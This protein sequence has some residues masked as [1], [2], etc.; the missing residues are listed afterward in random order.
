[1]TTIHPDPDTASA[2]PRR[3]LH[4]AGRVPPIVWVILLA[5]VVRLVGLVVL[6]PTLDFSLPGNAIHGSEGYDEYA[7]NL[8]ATGVY[9]RTP[10]VA[11]AGLPPFYSYVLAAVY[12]VAGRSFVTVALFHIL[13][14]SVSILLLYRIG[15]GIFPA[16]R[17][18]GRPT[19]EWVG[20]L[21][22]LFTALYPYLV[23]QNLTLVDTP[24]WM[25]LL[26]GFVWAMMRLRQA[27]QTRSAVAFALLSGLL[28]GIATL[29]RPITPPL[30]LLLA[31]WFWLRLSLWQ[32]MWRLALVA[33]VSIVLVLPWIARNYQ[34]FDEFVLMSTT[35]GFN[36]WQGNH[37]GTVPILLSG[38]DVQ[39]FGPDEALI[40]AD[41]T[42]LE[43]DRIGYQLA[44][45]FWR[46]QPQNIAGL[47]LTKFRVYW[48]I[49]I[50]PQRNPQYGE[51]LSVADDGTITVERG[52]TS[53]QGVT[54]A[55][56]QYDSGLFDTL[57]RPVHILYFGGLFL[58]ACVGSLLA[59]PYWRDVSLVW[60][61]Q[62]S[63]T[64]IYVL[65]HPSTRYR[66]PTDPLLFLLSAYTLVRLLG[67]WYERRGAD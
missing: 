1:M 67:W 65:F 4:R 22:A 54:E 37:D 35:S 11:D 30:A 58:L 41:A 16:V 24:L 14:D 36:L 47:M 63:M 66:A 10:G 13:L 53:Q 33:V 7:V 27:T 5:I 60:M 42:D 31:L 3:S 56:V 57:G 49:P 64:I 50:T 12:G 46:Q 19:A 61:V 32:G 48:H 9:G 34:V 45:D 15:L 51:R 59:L 62:V 26:L 17:V 18:A 6:A 21:A 29:T 43:R 2:V 28:L 44:L 40:P 55:N 20:L 25:T 23:F 38:Y 39:W 8:L 52:T